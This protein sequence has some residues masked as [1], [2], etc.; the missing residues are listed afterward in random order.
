MRKRYHITT[1]SCSTNPNQKLWCVWDADKRE[2]VTNG[3]QLV[4]F[5]NAEDADTFCCYLNCKEEDGNQERENHDKF[6]NSTD[7]YFD[8]NE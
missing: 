3:Y 6:R 7:Y 4:T 2:D 5:K 8:Q 1:C